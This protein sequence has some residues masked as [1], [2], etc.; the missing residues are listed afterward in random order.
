[1]NEVTVERTVAAPPE[2]VFAASI[3]VPRWPEIV[4]AIQK[5][6]LL[7]SGPVGVGTRFRETRL[8]FGREATETMEVLEFEPPRRYLLGAE[9][10]GS[11]YRTEFRF[12]PEGAGTRVVFTFRAE[13]LT[14]GAKVMGVLMKPMLKKMV[15]M[16]A[17]DLD[18]LK[19]H[20]EGR[21]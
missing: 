7:S 12:E 8:F 6:E 3:D 15:A 11:R 1:M 19:A 10:H 16:C 17:A 14:F 13:P 21:G 4:P 5:V 20:V 9:S 18:A 2:R